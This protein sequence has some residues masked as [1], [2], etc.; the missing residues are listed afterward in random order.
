MIT[1]P[2]NVMRLT[3]IATFAL[4][5]IAIERL[6]ILAYKLAKPSVKRLYDKMAASSRPFSVTPRR[7]R[8]TVDRTHRPINGGHTNGHHHTKK[9]KVVPQ[10]AE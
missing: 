10:A 3:M 6:T 5:G 4:G 7:K 8:R 9:P 1:I 2:Q